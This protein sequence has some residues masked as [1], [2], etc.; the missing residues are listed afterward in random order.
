MK[1]IR[2]LLQTNKWGKL[3]FYRNTNTADEMSKKC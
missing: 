1:G 2:S 3:D